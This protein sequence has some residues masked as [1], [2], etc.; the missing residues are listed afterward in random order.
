MRVG[1]LDRAGGS[2]NELFRFSTTDLK[3]DQLDATSVSGSPLSG[4]MV[5]VGSDLYV[6]G[7]NTTTGEEGLFDDGHAR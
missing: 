4:G 5:S 1:M 6:F 3:W 7:G 2:S